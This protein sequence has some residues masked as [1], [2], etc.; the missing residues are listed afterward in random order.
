MIVLVGI[1]LAAAIAAPA[2]FLIERRITNPRNV[3]VFP[4]GLV[5][6]NITGAALAGAVTAATTGDVRTILLVGLCGAYT[7]F[8]GF[9]LSAVR[10]ARRHKML[11]AAYVAITMLGSVGA[12]LI[13][14][15]AFN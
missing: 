10:L 13:T 3:D 9:A 14:Q 4:W 1:A 15:A 2:R 7:T 6:V 5:V 12:F 8:S 11:A